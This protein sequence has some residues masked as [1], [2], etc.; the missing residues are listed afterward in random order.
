MGSNYLLNSL[1][2]FGQD[3]KIIFTF[4]ETDI[5]TKCRETGEKPVQYPLL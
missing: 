3:R 2:N 5:K 1:R 4:V